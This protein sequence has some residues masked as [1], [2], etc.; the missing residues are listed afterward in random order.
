MTFERYEDFFK[1][2][3]IIVSIYGRSKHP[4]IYR[5]IYKR[6]VLLSCLDSAQRQRTPLPR[7]DVADTT[8]P[9]TQDT[10]NIFGEIAEARSSSAGAL[11]AL[12]FY[13]FRIHPKPT[14]EPEVIWKNYWNL[15]IFAAG[16]G[17]EIGGGGRARG[18]RTLTSYVKRIYGGRTMEAVGNK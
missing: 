9:Q 17:G 6:P 11:Q 5:E 10:E 12:S 2:N 15:Q 8:Q 1:F 16:S 7:D 13:P 14:R 3:S 4:T 18:R